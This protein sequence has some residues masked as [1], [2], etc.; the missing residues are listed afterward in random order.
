MKRGLVLV[1]MLLVAA[2]G[3]GSEGGDDLS[4]EELFSQTV[5]EGQAGCSTC[6]SLEPDDVIVG[7]SLASI[8]TV[9]ASRVEG[10]TAAEYIEQSIRDPRAHVVEGFAAGT[11]P[12]WDGV[13]SDAQ[14]NALVSYLLTS[15]G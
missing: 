9:A 15:T 5:L 8:G 14:V 4:G 7:P 3:G 2:C 13:L 10:L 6:H 12:T 1:L 11:M